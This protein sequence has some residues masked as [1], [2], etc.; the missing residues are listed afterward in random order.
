LKLCDVALAEQMSVSNELLAIEAS[1]HAV[2]KR[3][4]IPQE[5]G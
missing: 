1:H 3:L 2:K 4:L 5:L